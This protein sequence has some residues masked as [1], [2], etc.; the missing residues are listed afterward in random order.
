[1]HSGWQFWIDRGG[2]FTDVVGRAPDGSIRIH[3]LLSENPEQYPD[4]AIQG[5]RDLLGLPGLPARIECGEGRAQDPQLLF[6]GDGVQQSVQ[7]DDGHSER[8]RFDQARR[9]KI[10]F[11]QL[12]GAL[13]IIRIERFPSERQHR[14]RRIDTGH[15][16]PSRRYFAQDPSR[17]AAQLQH[18]PAPELAAQA[19][20]T[21]VGKVG[22]VV[23]HVGGD[24]G[25]GLIPGRQFVPRRI[26]IRRRNLAA[27]K[28]PC[29]CAKRH[30][31][32][33]ADHQHFQPGRIAH[34]NDG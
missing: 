16:E 3:K 27:R 2:T 8:S 5:I 6:L 7:S 32:A 26:G 24:H 9:S 21:V 29:A 34:E 1:M 30:A 18:P 28:H 11:Q 20:L 31:G 15:V 4:A 13:Q 12:D 10:P 17:A 14:S 25:R 19:Q 23:R 22:A 33:T